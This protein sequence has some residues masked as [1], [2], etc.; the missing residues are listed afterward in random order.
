MTDFKR[1]ILSRAFLLAIL[2]VGISILTG[3]GLEQWL[4]PRTGGFV[5]RVHQNFHVEM[6]VNGLHS[7]GFM[8]FLP[9]WAVIPY[10]TALIDDIKS[11]Y[12]RFYLVRTKKNRYVLNKI[13]SAVS[14]GGLAIFAGVMLS[15][16]LYFLAFSPL[17]VLEEG[18]PLVSMFMTVLSTALLDSLVG[19][20]M[21]ALGAALA[22]ATLSKHICYA[23]PFVIYYILIVLNER[24][25]RG[26]YYLYPRE[27]LY[28]RGEWALGPAGAA[29]LLAGLTAVFSLAFVLLARRRVNHA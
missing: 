3:S 7:D 17:E 26:L 8:L 10:T 11:G 9:L 2:G 21:A 12:A 25:Y 27:W 14:A 5:S 22:A 29:L 28:I 23:F 20:L 13:I 18:G 16:L 24:Y 4:D 6:L 15:Y 1:A 19:M